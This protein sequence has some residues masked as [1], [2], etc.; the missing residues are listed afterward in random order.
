M[1]SVDRSPGKVAPT[2]T[3][4]TERR[5]FAVSNVKPAKE[6]L[7]EVPC[8]KV[9]AGYAG[10]GVEACSSYHGKLVQFRPD[11][12]SEETEA[13]HPLIAA[14]HGAFTEHRPVALSPDIVWLTLTWGLAQ[15][16]NLHAEELRHHFVGHEGKV[17]ITVRRDDFIKGSP[18]NP[19]P[20]AFTAFSERVREHIGAAA[21]E[22]IVADFSTTGPVE[23]AASE[24]VLLDAMQAYFA[25]EFVS[26]CGI[27]SITLEG[28]V[29]DWAGIVR[30]VRDWQRFGLDWWVPHV[31]PV[32]EQFVAAAKG[33]VD[34]GFWE[35]IYKWQGPQGSGSAYTTGWISTLFPYLDNP[36]H[37]YRESQPPVRR[38]PWL[39]KLPKDY[40]P[41]RSDFAGSP[42]RAPFVWL[43]HGLEFAMEFV[44][45]LMGVR[46]DHETLCLR[47]EIGWAV[48]Q[49]RQ[50]SKESAGG[51]QEG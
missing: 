24:V 15:H 19:W 8:Y 34:R 31:V 14:L 18:E 29:E 43:Y 40:G 36:A 26:L 3:P 9:I 10:S 23:R 25:Y 21:H 13:A 12:W 16:I 44:G 28:T 32:L 48:R 39:G 49:V 27:P 35:S 1:S 47:P 41:S 42:G 20:E 2:T 11:P 46:Q 37:R 38:N 5:T 51:N 22:L 17:K 4:A 33:N 6:P 30:R 45:G 50:E 7:P